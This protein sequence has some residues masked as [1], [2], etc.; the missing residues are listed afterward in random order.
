MGERWAY[1]VHRDDPLLPVEVLRVGR[2]RPARVLVRFVEDRFEG[3]EQWVPPTRLKTRWSSVSRYRA[4]ERRWATLRAGSPG[5]ESTEYLAAAWVID[6]LLDP[7]IATAGHNQDAGL[8]H[9]HDLDQLARTLRIDPARLAA[10]P[11][12]T[13]KRTL[14]VGWPA[15]RLIAR[16]TARRNP[17]PVLRH[18]HR[19]QSDYQHQAIY[20]RQLPHSPDGPG[21]YLDAEWFISQLD[22]PYHQP[23]WTLLRH[24][25][26]KPAR[27]RFDELVTLRQEIARLGAFADATIAALRGVGQTRLADRLER[28][29][30]AHPDDDHD[31]DVLRGR[32]T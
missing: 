32:K 28:E 31:T 11:A 4:R 1:R 30:G 16:T 9:I 2:Q 23:Y 7:Q 22:A 14:V 20:G 13:D 8:T 26:G 3:R 18:V 15:T 17:S 25:C 21:T 24:W 10:E 27:N 29:H 19:E 5:R 12:F 6:H